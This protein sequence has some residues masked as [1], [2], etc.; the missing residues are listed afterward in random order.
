MGD[1]AGVGPEVIAKALAHADVYAH[2]RPIVIGDADRL[3]EA[4]ALCRLALKVAR[5]AS[6]AAGTY[7]PGVVDCMDLGLVPRGLAFGKLSEAAGDLDA[8]ARQYGLGTDFVASARCLEMLGRYREAG[9]TYEKRLLDAPDDPFAS[10]QL[11][12]I[13]LRFGRY[14]IAAKHLQTAADNDATAPA[15]LRG[16][17]V[18]LQA[19]GLVDGARAYVGSENFTWTSIERNREAGLFLT[20]RAAVST[21]STQFEDDWGNGGSF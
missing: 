2:C 13:L 7:E 16:L 11:G 8:A 1:A 10:L 17:V 21:I 12:R 15:A 4:V 6:P 20:E 19:M 5:V 3:E 9:R 14:E 18:A